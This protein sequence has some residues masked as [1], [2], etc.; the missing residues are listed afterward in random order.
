MSVTVTSTIDFTGLQARLS[1]TER[2]VFV[3]HE[4]KILGR[5][6]A[7]WRGWRYEGRPASAP[8]NV[9]GRAW[10]S[11]IETTEDKARL[12]IFNLAEADG[13][14]YAGH[15]HRSGTRTLEWTVIWASC[16]EDLIPAM[17][18]DLKREVAKTVGQRG[19]PKKLRG[20]SGA[21]TTVNAGGSDL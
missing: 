21:G 19:A 9:S 4:K 1:D 17:V 10:K 18:A 14:R 5:F 11:R 3:R 16:Q 15:V 20:R 2:R 8:R 7:N 12:F 13:V 6:K